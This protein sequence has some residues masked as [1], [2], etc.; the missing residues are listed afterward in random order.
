MLDPDFVRHW[1]AEVVRS[2][3]ERDAMLYALSLGIGGQPLDP[4]ELQFVYERGL[5]VLPSM[6]SNIVQPWHPWY[7]VASGIEPVRVIHG[8]ER[9]QLRAPL[10]APASMH[11]HSRVTS[12]VDKGGATPVTATVTHMLHDAR[13]GI[14][15]GIVTNVLMLRGAGGTNANWGVGARPLAPL[16]ARN[17]DDVVQLLTLPQAALLHRLCGDANPL[18]VELGIARAEGFPRPPLHGLCTFGITG[19]ALIRLYCGNDA[20]RLRELAARFTAPVYPGDTIRLEIWREG[21]EGV[22]FRGTVD[23]RRTVV[24][25]RGT[26]RV[27]AGR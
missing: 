18:H 6:L 11:V 2:Y 17:P 15:M 1:Q 12:L 7:D 25:D 13:S 22:R 5:A 19:Y 27:A 9:V 23:A 24:L 10:I 8:E 14:E 26:A 21:T 16:P 20:G 3:T 4:E